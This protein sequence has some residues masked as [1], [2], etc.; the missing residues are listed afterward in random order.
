MVQ[1]YSMRLIGLTF[2]VTTL[3]LLYV[4][5]SI[6]GVELKKAMIDPW[7]SSNITS[8]PVLEQLVYLKIGSRGSQSRCP[9]SKVTVLMSNYREKRPAHRFHDCHFNRVPPAA[10][11]A[12]NP[13]SEGHSSTYHQ[14]LYPI[15]KGG[16]ST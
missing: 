14:C 10:W 8:V 4:T 16:W 5:T 11:K 6:R 1:W 3:V 7:S 15:G 2:L 12:L 9:A 13:P